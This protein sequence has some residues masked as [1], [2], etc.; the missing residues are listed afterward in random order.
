MK[1]PQV[2]AFIG[3]GVMGSPMARNLLAAGFKVNLYSRTA[4]KVEHLANYGGRVAGSIAEATV[5][6]QIVITMLPDSPDVEE[7]FLGQGGF[8][9]LLD[10]ARS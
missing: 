7:V 6:A 10:L 8:S 4:H 5:D 3:L 2:I 9:N 1:I